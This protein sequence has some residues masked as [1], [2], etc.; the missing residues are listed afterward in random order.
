MA[1]FAINDGPGEA[2]FWDTRAFGSARDRVLKIVEKGKRYL[3]EGR[4]AVR[5]SV[6]ITKIEYRDYPADGKTKTKKATKPAKGK[7]AL[8][9]TAK[10]LTVSKASSK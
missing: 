4:L 10:R 6:T 8:R 5:G 3:I 1:R 2:A 7:V 9:A